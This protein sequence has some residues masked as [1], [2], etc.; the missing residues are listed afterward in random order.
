MSKFSKGDVV[1]VQATVRYNMDA[2][3]D[4]VGIEVEKHHP[5][6]FVPLGKVTLVHRHFEV[7]AR[8]WSEGEEHYGHI[9]AIHGGLAWVE[10][11]EV[12]ECFRTIAL[13]WLEKAPVPATPLL[14]AA[15]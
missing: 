10:L 1:T 15:E 6:V 2:D 8:V 3:D 4:Q 13:K 5:T 14:E 9:R 11:E 12:Q 7:G